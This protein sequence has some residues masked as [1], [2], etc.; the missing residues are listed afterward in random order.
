MFAHA[1]QRI[2]NT[3]TGG[4]MSVLPASLA[5]A[6]AELSLRPVI[7]D[8][9]Q[10]VY[11]LQQPLLVICLVIAVAVFAT[12]IY[13]VVR[14][15]RSGDAGTVQFH[16]STLVEIIW[17]T[18]PFIILFITAA[19]SV[20][21]V[22]QTDAGRALAEQIIPAAHASELDGVM[23]NGEA[24]Y[25]KVCASCHQVDGEGLPPTF[26][27]LAGSPIV[28]GDVTQ[29]VNIVLNGRPGTAMVSMADVLSDTEIAAVITY[30]R[31]A[32]GNNSGDVVI[33]ADVQAMRDTSGS[34]GHL[35]SDPAQEDDELAAATRSRTR[36]GSSGG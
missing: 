4:V 3:L 17:T 28:T 34:R 18:I 14:H 16:K 33:P 23:V 12:V 24:V 31:N 27:A 30:V 20:K 36:S 26:P 7:T 29:S 25:R 19:P 6:D 10:N 2:R 15:R 1:F 21:T 8:A 32:W 35:Q 22:I 11:R 9:G 5:F 13:S